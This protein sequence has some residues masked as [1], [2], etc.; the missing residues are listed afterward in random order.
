MLT[1]KDLQALGT[2]IDEKLDKRITESESRFRK[3]IKDAFSDFYDNIF[4]PFVER[5]QK[6]HVE[7]KETIEK[8]GQ[9]VY[10]MKDYIKDH[11][12]RIRK[13]E[14]NIIAF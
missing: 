5:N 7:L 13:I 3:A 1:K 2:T 12:N 8:V 11:E 6:V 10:E 4:E 14:K 9:D